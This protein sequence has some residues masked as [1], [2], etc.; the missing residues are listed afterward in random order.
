[1]DALNKAV[2]DKEG[3]PF[4][5]ADIMTYWLG[6]KYLMRYLVLGL[7]RVLIMKSKIPVDLMMIAKCAATEKKPSVG[8]G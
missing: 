1:L 2:D 5:L 8:S 6:G 4:Q 7:K 3:G